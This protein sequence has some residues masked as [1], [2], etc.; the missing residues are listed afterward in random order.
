MKPRISATGRL[1]LGDDVTIFY[2]YLQR[3]NP[4]RDRPTATNGQ[5]KSIKR[6][7]DDVL[8]GCLLQHKYG[9]AIIESP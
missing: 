7:G 6:H 1:F 9:T 2:M 8:S 4:N 5:K 3:K